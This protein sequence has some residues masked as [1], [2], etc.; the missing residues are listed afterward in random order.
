MKTRFPFALL[1][2]DLR[3]VTRAD[4]D[5]SSNPMPIAVYAALRPII[6]Q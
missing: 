2:A 3:R 1:F 6:D 4:L 5:L